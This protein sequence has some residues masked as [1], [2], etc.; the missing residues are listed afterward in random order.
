MGRPAVFLDRDGTLNV[1]KNYVHRVEDWE[2]LPGAVD[3]I[4]VFN[5][6][7]LP[8]IVITNQAGVA[9]GYYDEAAVERLHRWVDTR[10]AEHAARIDAYYYCP[11]HPEF[12]AIRDCDCRKPLP[13]ML[14]RAGRDMDLDLGTCYMVGDKMSDIQAAQAAHVKPVFVKTGYGAQESASRPADCPVFDN[15]LEAAHH[16]VGQTVHA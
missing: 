5:R 9:R 7:G 8:V 13:G 10:L 12:G 6:A 2:W 11:H 15:L 3:A 1:E 14:L 4:R 16:I